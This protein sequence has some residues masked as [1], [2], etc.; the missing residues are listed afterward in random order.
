MLLSVPPW[1][2]PSTLTATSS[3]AFKCPVAESKMNEY[4]FAVPQQLP[5]GTLE[6]IAIPADVVGCDDTGTNNRLKTT[7]DLDR[8][9][10]VIPIKLLQI[11]R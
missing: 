10:C 8:T 5:P 9:S 11:T 4:R 7:D 2:N 1:T 3:K 6:V